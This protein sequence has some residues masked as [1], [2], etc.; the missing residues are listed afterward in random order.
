MRH[1]APWPFMLLVLLLATVVVTGCGGTPTPMPTPAPRPTETP[2]PAITAEQVNAALKSSPYIDEVHIDKGLTCQTCHPQGTGTPPT[3]ATC[4]GC[5][6]PA[7]TDLAAKTKA[8]NPNPHQSHLG[9]ETCTTCHAVHGP[10][11]YACG[12][13]HSEYQYQG[14]FATTPSK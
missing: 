14:R 2:K 11:V 12:Q 8:L 1:A 9:E 5:H 13:C 6:G 4:L 7:Y 10:F 3:A